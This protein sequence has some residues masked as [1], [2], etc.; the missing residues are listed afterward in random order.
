MTHT[1]KGGWLEVSWAG[2]G[3]DN[4]EGKVFTVFKTQKHQ[5][6]ANFWTSLPAVDSDENCLGYDV[7][8]QNF[9]VAEK[10]MRN[11]KFFGKKFTKGTAT[12]G[13]YIVK[14]YKETGE[15]VR[16]AIVWGYGWTNNADDKDNIE[17][18]IKPSLHIPT[19]TRLQTYLVQSWVKTAYMIPQNMPTPT[20]SPTPTPTATPVITSY[21][22]LASKSNVIEGDSV[23]ISLKTINVAKGTKVFATCTHPTECG[24]SGLG[25][26]FQIDENGVDSFTISPK[27]SNDKLTERITFILTS[28]TSSQLGDSNWNGKSVSFVLEKASTPTPTPKTTNLTQPAQKGDTILQIPQSDQQNFK[29]NDDIVIDKNTEIEEYNKI[30]GF[31][32]LKLARALKYDHGLNAMIEVAEDAPDQTPTPYPA[33]ADFKIT[34]ATDQSLT[35]EWS[36]VSANQDKVELQISD[37]EDFSL[38]LE[39]SEV[40]EQ[41]ETNQETF[42]GLVHSKKYYI[43]ISAFVGSDGASVYATTSGFTTIPGN[44]LVVSKTIDNDLPKLDWSEYNGEYKYVNVFRHNSES[45]SFEKIISVNKSDATFFVDT[46]ATTDGVYIYKLSVDNGFTGSFTPTFEIKIDTTPPEVPTITTESNLT[47]NKTPTWN[48][49]SVESNVAYEITLDGNVVTIIK[50]TSYKPSSNLNDGEHILEVSAIDSFGN[51]SEKGISKVVVDTTPPTLPNISAP[52]SPTNNKRPAWTRNE[53]A[54]VSKYG[55]V[56]SGDAETF[57]TDTSF[58]PSQDLNDGSYILQI[59]AYDEAGNVS[60]YVASLVVVDTSAPS[61]TEISVDS[62]TNNNKPTWTWTPVTGAVEYGV[63]LN[64]NV[65]ITQTQLTFTSP[66][67]LSDGEHTLKVRSRDGVGNW[68]DYVSSVVKIDTTPPTKPVIIASSPTSNKRPTLVA[69]TPDSGGPFHYEFRLNDGPVISSE[70]V[71]YIPSV[72][73]VDGNYTFYA[74]VKDTLNNWSEW[75]SKEFIVDLTPPS[76]PVIAVQSPTSNN[77][78]TWTWDAVDGAV[79]YGIILNNSAETLQPGAIRTYTPQ[80]KLSDGEHTLKVRSQDSVGNMSEYATSKIVVDTTAPLKPVVTSETAQTA[81][82]KPTWNWDGISQ[83]PNITMEFIKKHVGKICFRVLSGNKF[84]FENNRFKKREG[85]LLLE[86]V[87]SFHKLQNLYVINQY[88]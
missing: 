19:A 17:L 45:S 74:R 20:P 26:E 11:K 54:D 84:T 46:S 83:N 35:V 22:L 29:T 39:T 71:T 55:V 67:S 57:T 5:L 14:M 87:R 73:L 78:P 49:N 12:D 1:A 36:L 65:E 79:G 31:G 27:L 68:S 6:V 16:D 81:N 2:C 43:R 23:S 18:Y 24:L 10:Q 41:D 7:S 28:S 56:F 77:Q 47:N 21:Q 69:S 88:M 4:F 42:A 75:S 72:D 8:T 53:N 80:D 30:V 86:K 58:I 85:H 38:I 63:V 9:S 50:T 60:D 48:W 59:R 82:N 44:N 25:V 62:P 3:K 32:S 15:Y 40:F 51:K 37:K 61:L 13:G 52:S 70:S 76:V 33:P 64:S 34:N 66:I